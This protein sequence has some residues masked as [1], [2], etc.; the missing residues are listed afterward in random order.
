MAYFNALV[1]I[2]Q[3]DYIDLHIYPIQ[4]DFILDRVTEV[5]RLARE[6][7][8]GVSI[9]EAWLYKV[10]RRELGRISPVKAFARDVYSFWQPLDAQFL[11]VI[12]NLSHHTEAEFCS[13]FWMKYLYGYLDYD[14]NTRALRPQQL[15]NAVDSLAGR[16]ILDGQL[17]QTGER[18][19]IL[20]APD[21]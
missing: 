10:S 18:L 16:Q 20:I 13:F 14:A 15:I 12:V 4:R 9:G 11:E 6:Q 21:Q 8:K 17:N 3:L 19:K 5:T 1:R 7:E 2:P